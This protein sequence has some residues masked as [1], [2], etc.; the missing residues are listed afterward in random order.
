MGISCSNEEVFK[1]VNNNKFL[2]EYTGT[3]EIL[4]EIFL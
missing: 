3:V 2:S 4:P 1:D